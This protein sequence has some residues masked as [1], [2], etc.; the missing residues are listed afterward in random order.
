[1]SNW[2]LLLCNL[3]DI[4]SPEARVEAATEVDSDLVTEEVECSDLI[5]CMASMVGRL[6]SQVVWLPEDYLQRIDIRRP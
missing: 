5:L 1:M 4:T 6:E 3:E 2:I